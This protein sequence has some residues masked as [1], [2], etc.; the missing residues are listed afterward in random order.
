MF[1][2]SRL[3]WM[4]WAANLLI[5]YEVRIWLY[6]LIN[7]ALL[8]RVRLEYNSF[9][10]GLAGRPMGIRRLPSILC[11]IQ[12]MLTEVVYHSVMLAFCPYHFRLAS[13]TTLFNSDL[14]SKNQSNHW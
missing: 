8:T 10:K 7:S 1:V 5:G 2:Y 6:G 12:F 3:C 13:D 14:T 9:S 11:I 4:I